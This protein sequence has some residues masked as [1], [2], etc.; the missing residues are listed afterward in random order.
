MFSSSDT[1]VAVATPGGRAGLGIVRLSGPAA[2]R[3]ALTLIGRDTPLD[4]RRATLARLRAA[5]EVFDHTIVTYFAQ[6]HSYTTE[7]IVEISAHGSPLVL[8]QIVR[9]AMALGARLARPGEFTFRAFINGRIDLTQ[10]EAVADL[11]EAVTPR[12]ARAASA[13]LDGSLGL[14]LRALDAVLFD[15]AAR[16][17]ASLDF[18]DEGYHF[19]QPSEV[20][21]ELERLRTDVDD[22]LSDSSEGLLVRDGVRVVIAG[23]TN[24]GKSSIFNHLT[25]SERAIV[26]A[27]PG[28]TR[29]VLVE[30]IDLNGVPVTLVDTAGVREAADE[31]EREGVRRAADA[32]RS[33]DLLMLVLDLSEPLQ[34]ED[35][36][37]IE[38]TRHQRRILA[39]NKCDRHP[40]WDPAAIVGESIPWC[41]LSIRTGQGVST[42]LEI[43]AA[44]LGASFETTDAPRVTNE[45]HIQLLRRCAASLQRAVDESARL[46]AGAPEELLLFEL[47]GARA[48]LDEI[49]GTRTPE[50]VLERIF[51]RFCIGK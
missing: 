28:T 39:A 19:L 13:Q 14:R 7:D 8:Q 47:A 17:E 10:A 50:D 26:T 33:A 29:D 36:A 43:V 44:A 4:D 38:Q 45:R 35:L 31:I 6:P 9:S 23:R 25:R 42:L 5:D 3:I 46:G 16:L 2:H 20:L 40:A 24:V 32:A 34:A 30:A 22:L 11:I 48:A 12:Q 15:L 51:A 21:S 27:L 18:P 41:V 1:I 49:A 37:L